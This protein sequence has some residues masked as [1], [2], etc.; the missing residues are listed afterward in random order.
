M[1]TLQ[2]SRVSADLQK[3]LVRLDFSIGSELKFRIRRGTV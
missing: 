2:V 1:S 3:D